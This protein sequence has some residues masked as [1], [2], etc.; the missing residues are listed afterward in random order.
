MYTA[1][2]KYVAEWFQCDR[3]WP[4]TDL[5]K[6]KKLSV[7]FMNE[8][9]NYWKYNNNKISCDVI[10]KFLK[11]SWKYCFVI[12]DRKEKNPYIRVKFQGNLLCNL[13]C[14]FFTFVH[15]FQTKP[16]V[17]GQ[18]LALRLST[19]VHKNLLWFLTSVI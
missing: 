12:A 7:F 4:I 9:P 5:N 19:L 15:V 14:D 10:M 8:C 17:T 11:E 16:V 18:L 1:D 2:L 6:S 13:H 3:K